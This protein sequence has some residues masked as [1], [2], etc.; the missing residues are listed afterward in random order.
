MSK[1]TVSYKQQDVG[2]DYDAILIGSGIGSMTTAALL[3]KEGWRCLVL[4][5]HYMPGGYTHVFKRK[6]YEWDVGVHYIGEVNR[7]TSF[8]ARLFRYVTDGTLEWADMGDVYDRIRFG[9]EIYDFVKGREAFTEQLKTYFP[10]DA[11]AID[12]YIVEVRNAARGARNFFAEKALSQMQSFI[13]GP[14]LRKDFKKYASKTTLEVLR[15]LTQNEKLIAVLTGQYG[16]YGH[17]PAQSSFAMHA[18]VVRHYLNGGTYPVGGSGRIFESYVSGIEQ[19]GG[20]IATNAEVSEILMEKGKATGVRMADDRVIR[21]PVVISGAGVH[22]TI[23]RLLPKAEAQKTGLLQKSQNNPASACH[24]GLYI[25]FK[26]SSQSL[27]LPKANWWY[28]PPVYD[29]DKLCADFLADP[30]APFPV[31][32]V[33]FPSAKDPSWDDRYPN[34]STVDVI[35]LTNYE[36]FRE[37]EGTKWHKR[38][39]AYEAKKAEF[40]ERLLNNLY[41]L[42]PQLKGKVDH[43]ELSTPLSTQ[44]FCNYAQGEIYGIQHTPDR[45]EERWLKPKTPIKNLY[46]SGQDVATAGVGGAMMGGVLC[47][48]SV[49]GKNMMNDIMT[50]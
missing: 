49:L 35:T 2:D 10:D 50:A 29:H 40:T 33:S 28:Y 23:N 5:R 1:T 3:A 9:D 36:W 25:G 41:K 27:N 19:A 44:Q 7:E 46:L 16:D 6:G 39:E 31:T 21:A 26:E 18:M 32:Y 43:A 38:G 4:E 34:R 37:W 24:L 15:S 30:N 42:E 45:F 20:L 22:T 13:A 47:A 8:L 48:V 12:Q 14:F 17:P 11:K